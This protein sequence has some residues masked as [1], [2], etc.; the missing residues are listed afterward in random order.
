MMNLTI[1]D[2]ATAGA[3]LT[4]LKVLYIMSGK[5][6][7]NENKAGQE[8]LPLQSTVLWVLKWL[9]VCGHDL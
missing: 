1:D 3:L 8:I 4:P 9:F 7:K 6:R 5:R 2:N